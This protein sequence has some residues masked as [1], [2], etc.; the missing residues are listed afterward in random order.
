[1]TTIREAQE[2]VKEFRQKVLPPGVTFN[3]QFGKLLEEVA[4]TLKAYNKGDRTLLADGLG[5][6]LYVLL[7]CAGLAGVD[8]QSVFEKIHASNMT[9][10]RDGTLSPK[11]EG[12]VAPKLDITCSYCGNPYG[13]TGCQ[14]S[15]G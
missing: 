15:H 14:R 10:T 2:Q 6:T 3:D 8:L 5:D 12:Y 4:E 7:G 1:V 13:S 11:G 9:K